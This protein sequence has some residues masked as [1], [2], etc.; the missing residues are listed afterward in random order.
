[1]LCATIISFGLFDANAI[2]YGLDQMLEAS[3]KQLIAFIQWYY[4]WCHEVGQLVP[5]CFVDVSWC[6]LV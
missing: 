1:M 6:M 2:Q 5:F 4:Y 3:T